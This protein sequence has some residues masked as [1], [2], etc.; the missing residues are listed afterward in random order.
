MNDFLLIFRRDFTSKEAQPSPEKLQNS[1]N[2]WKNWFGGIAAQNKLSRPLQRWDLDG[3]VVKPNKQIINGPF[4]E[5]KES[6]GGLVIIKAKDYNE[7][8]EIAEGCP[9]LNLGGTVEVRMETSSEEP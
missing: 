3:K 2:D 1:V 8:V 6:I 4:V 9:I 5:I 7:A